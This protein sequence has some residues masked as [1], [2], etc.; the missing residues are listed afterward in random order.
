M[1][2][3]ALQDKKHFE[4]IAQNSGFLGKKI[5][6][7]Y[8]SQK[9]VDNNL[10][11]V[12]DNA[13]FMLSGNNI[14]LCGDITE[15][16]LEEIISFSFFVSA[17]TIETQILN[18]PLDIDKKIYIMEYVGEPKTE[19]EN[20]E[21]NKNIYSFAKFS[22]DNFN[23]ISFDM[24]YSNFARKVNKELSNIYYIEDN[25][26]IISG[27]ISTVYD[28]NTVYITFVS[29]DKEYRRQGLAKNVIDYIVKHNENKTILLTCECKLKEFYEKIGFK[30]I[31]YIEVFNI[32]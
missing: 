3:N 7:E 6:S 16:N 24:A 5:Y 32:K 30:N 22:C 21:I 31:D 1:I 10:F 18:L 20:I 23:G 13:V 27:A 9:G 8:L 29:T 14:T 17:K 19:I 4:N 28:E 26:K 2:V 11:Y 25:S 12:I 15:E